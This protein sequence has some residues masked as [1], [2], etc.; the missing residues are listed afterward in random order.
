MYKKAIKMAP[1]HLGAHRYLAATYIHL[2]REE[3]AR[4]EAAE[5]IRINPKFFLE[6]F[7]KRISQKNKAA[8]GRYIDALRKAG[9][10]DRPPLPLPD[11][12][13]IGVLPFVNMSGDPEQEYFS[14]GLTEEIISALSKV[15][16]LLVIAR[17]STFTYKGKPVKV[18]KVSEELGVRYVLEGSVRKAG[19]RVRITAQLVDATTGH[20][21]WSERYD[22]D[23]KDI[24]ALQ[25]EI[26]MKI[27]VVMQVKLTEGEGARLHGKG[28]DNL[29]AYLKFLQG[30]KHFLRLNPDD[31]ILSR[32]YFKEAIALDPEFATPYAFM[33][34]I[35][36]A[37]VR[38]G[39]S[40][41]PQKSIGQAFK[42]AQKVLALDESH[43]NGHNLLGRVHYFKRQHEQAIAAFERA[44]ALDP[45][46]PSNIFWLGN[47]LSR[48]GRHQ[49]A[50]LH[51]K[52]LIRVNPLIPN[53]GFLG[54]GLAYTRL[55]RYE[56]AITEL[57][58][59]LHHR[60]D[61]FAAHLE[62]AACYAALGR[63]E[64]AH[65]EAAEVLRLN[66]KFSVNKSA[67]RLQ[68][69]DKAAKERYID[70]LREAGLPD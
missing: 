47:T 20:H 32:R 25:D 44:V 3:E 69:R 56:E 53:L 9:L 60:P 42:L 17:N 4:A 62:L 1:D 45:N 41:S 19:D 54:L 14:D 70:A 33:G 27:I 12:P 24:F 59:A 15:P 26:T 46:L 57:K 55:E 36:L 48:A 7:A 52:R 35:H 8:L 16:K 18:Q 37:E 49:E 65:A 38:Q 13:S 31:Q 51:F 5:V 23:L 39:R 61:F 67:K 21:L 10:P 30:R 22:R 29:E 63:E 58:K 50:I 68:I 34:F 64:E 6:G 40:K 66:P 2:G 28:T 43:P 11:K